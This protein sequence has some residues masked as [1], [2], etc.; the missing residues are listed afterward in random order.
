MRCERDARAAGEQHPHRLE[1]ARPHGV[2]ILVGDRCRLAVDPL[3]DAHRRCIACQRSGVGDRAAQ[4]RLQ[5]HTHVPV[6]VRVQL[7]PDREGRIGGARALHVDPHEH[8]VPFGGRE[9]RREV[10]ATDR[11]REI[12]P[13][14]AQLDRHVCLGGRRGEPVDQAEILRDRLV[15][16]GDLADVLAEDRDRRRHALLRERIHAPERVGDRLARDVA[17]RHAPHEGAWR[18]RKRRRQ[19]LVDRVRHVSRVARRPSARTFPARGPV[20]RRASGSRP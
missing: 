19:Q 8:R 12:K 14:C 18:V 15:G 2:G 10:L 11:V 1:V 17:A 3:A 9:H 16:L 6:P 13:E 5:D 7:T 4:H 20:P